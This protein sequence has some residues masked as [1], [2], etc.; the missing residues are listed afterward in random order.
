MFILISNVIILL[1]L[2]RNRFRPYYYLQTTYSWKILIIRAILTYSEIPRYFKP[3]DFSLRYFQCGHKNAYEIPRVKSPENSRVILRFF[4]LREWPLAS[5]VMWIRWLEIP[6]SYQSRDIWPLPVVE[7][8]GNRPHWSWDTCVFWEKQQQ[9]NEEECKLFLSANQISK[10]SRT[11]FI[12]VSASA[13][14]YHSTEKRWSRKHSH[15]GTVVTGYMYVIQI[16]NGEFRYKSTDCMHAGQLNKRTHVYI[17]VCI[18]WRDKHTHITLRGTGTV[19]SQTPELKTLV[20][21]RS[22]TGRAP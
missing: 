7:W 5:F 8:F 12:L 15:S 6:R 21:N 16:C 9:R 19:V 14:S 13:K 1:Q 3:W 20:N 10:K 4:Y 2:L 17:H 11:T 22:V 18:L